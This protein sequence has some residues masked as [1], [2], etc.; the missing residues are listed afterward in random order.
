MFFHLGSRCDS[1]FIFEYELLT[2]FEFCLI[3][4]KLN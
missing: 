2:G 1:W 4:H 3:D